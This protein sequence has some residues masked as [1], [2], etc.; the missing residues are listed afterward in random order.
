VNVPEFIVD[1]SVIGY[2]GHFHFGTIMS[3]DLRTFARG[4]F[5]ACMFSFI[6]GSYLGGEDLDR[7]V[8][9]SFPISKQFNS[10][11]SHRQCR[12]FQHLQILTKA[13]DFLFFKLWSGHLVDTKW[14]H[15]VTLMD[16]PN[17]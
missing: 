16:F 4:S 9:L 5:T 14:H 11:H 12:E 6:L 3:N 13:Q 8:S 17:D 15:I 1:L 7:M 2:L 10:L